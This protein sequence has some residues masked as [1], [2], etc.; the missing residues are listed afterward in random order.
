V[1]Q[2]DQPIEFEDN[3]ITLDIPFP[4]PKGIVSDDKAW[5][6]FSLVPPVVRVLFYS[7]RLVVMVL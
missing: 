2:H 7:I 4:P 1:C 5:K 3:Q 6:I